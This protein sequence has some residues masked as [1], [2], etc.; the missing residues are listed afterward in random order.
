[1]AQVINTNIMSMN[2]QRQ[3]NNTQNSMQTAIERLSS[4]LR[5]N[6]AKD[7][8]AGL[9]I[10]NQMTAQIRG[11]NQAMR[12]AGDGISL[13]QTAEGALQE[14]TNI[15]QRVRELAIQS[16][17]ATNS[18]ANRKSLQ[19]EVNQLV[20]ELNRIAGTT[21]FNGTT[22]LDGSFTSKSFQV[23][24]NAN[25]TISVNVAGADGQTLGINAVATDSTTGLG[26]ATATGLGTASASANGDGM[27]TGTAGTSFANALATA[28]DAS[29]VVTVTDAAGATQT[30]DFASLSNANA[31][32][33]ATALNNLTGV[34][35]TSGANSATMDLTNMTGIQDGDTV[36]FNIA[37]DG[38]STAISFTRDS[39]TNATLEAD[40]AAAITAAGGAGGDLTVATGTNSLTLSSAS[41]VNIGIENFDVVD[42]STATLSNFSADTVASGIDLDLS[43]ITIANGETI[44]IDVTVG[45]TSGTVSLTYNAAGG[46]LASQLAAEIDADLGL[47]VASDA[48]NVVTITSAANE[49]VTVDGLVLGGTASGTVAV[50]ADTGS[51][52]TGAA[53]NL[54][55]GGAET[56]TSEGDNTQSFTLNGTTVNVDLAGLDATDATVVAA[57]VAGAI[58][59]AAPANVTAVVNPGDN[60][61][62]LLT[63]AAESASNFAFAAGT[64]NGAGGTSSFDVAVPGSTASGNGTFLLDNADTESFTAVV[65]T[66][67]FDF[68]GATVTESGG[69]GGDSAVK[70]GGISITLDE[71]YSV[72]SDAAGNQGGIF[73]IAT[74]GTAQTLTT[75]GVTDVSAGNNVAAQTLSV[76]GEAA[77]DI[78]IVENA[79]AKNIAAA[80]NAESGTTGV[81]ALATT[82]ATLSE[83]SADGNVSFSLY[84]A[85]S[86]GVLIAATVTTS[87]LGSLVSAIN[88]KTGNTGITAELSSSGSSIT[89]TSASG[90]DIRLEN[91]E[92]SAAVTDTAGGNTEVEQTLTVTGSVGFAVNLADGGTTAEGS[93]LD[94]TA[95]G[96]EVTFQSTGTTF[97]VQSNI[98]AAGGGLFS[99]AAN[100]AKASNL[101]SVAQIDISTIAGAQDAISVLDGALAQVDSIRAD[102]GAIQNR[103]Q[104][105][106]S[107]LGATAENLSGARSRIQDADFAAETAELTRTQILQQAGVAMVAQANSL[108][109]TV[110]SLL[111]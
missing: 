48:G 23:G 67:S 36:S 32:D 85:N 84:G 31:P 52:L 37:R 61:Q 68:S 51:T 30:V 62:V 43:G 90:D 70:T 7:D 60:T 54:T 56:Y 24:A 108:P 89:L 10:A 47:T 73:G 49:T 77:S 53:G 45:G 109:Q 44:D 83:L 91:F 72:T 2:A 95:V 104:S 5:I 6:S 81:T 110:L 80:V 50:S 103:F 76:V 40:I 88:D 33:I 19:G 101:S 111:G 8:A 66:S 3:L 96:G 97:N 38:G 46:S 107:N 64:V 25:Q 9:A 21:S 57:A 17:N 71:G 16:A 59:T 29:Q 87:D 78:A 55:D 93:Q 34:T 35:A 11:L 100:E 69:T 12:N 14:S 1:M 75:S 102:L 82:T 20:S 42:L 105:T 98:A 99:G 79:S 4:G 28:I 15:L 65:E 63:S 26:A 86:D 39:A 106:I 22:L 27:N 94:S 18:A 13:A 41:G 74:A 92:H 58:T